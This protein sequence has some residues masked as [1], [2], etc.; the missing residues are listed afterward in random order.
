MAA[1]GGDIMKRFSRLMLGAAGVG[2]TAVGVG[3]TPA[4]VSAS[5]SHA[6]GLLDVIVKYAPENASFYGVEG[7]DGEVLDLKP[8]NVRR[9]EADLDAVAGALSGALES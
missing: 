6:A 3:D 5:N 9:Q 8:G 1:A 7:H 2:V 4:W